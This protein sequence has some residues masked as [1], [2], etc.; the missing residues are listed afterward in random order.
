MVF[1]SNAAQPE[2]VSAATGCPGLVANIE[3][4][5]YDGEQ[6]LQLCVAPQGLNIS[7][8][9]LNLRVYDSSDGIFRN[10]FEP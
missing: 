2:S 10:S 3:I 9:I 4:Q 6:V 7:N 8:G 5:D 1:A